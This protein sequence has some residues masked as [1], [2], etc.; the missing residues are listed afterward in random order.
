MDSL[1]IKLFRDK[2]LGHICSYLFTFYTCC[3]KTESNNIYKSQKKSTLIS[4]QVTDKVKPA[5]SSRGKLGD[6]EMTLSEVK[7][8]FLTYKNNFNYSYKGKGTD[9][10][11]CILANGFWQA[12]GYIGGIFRSELNFY[13]LC[14]ATQL[15]SEECVKFFLK[16]DK[17][18]SNKGTF[19]ITLNSFGKFVI[20]YRLSGWDTFFSVFVPYF[21]MLYGAKY[22]AIYKLKEIYK[23]KNFIKKNPDNMN[24]VLFIKLVYSLTPHSPRYKLS[25]EDKLVSLNL[26]PV[27]LKQLPNLSYPENNI[28]S[29]FL[30]ILGFFLGDGTLHLKMEWKRT[31]STIVILPLFN[32]KQSNVES[33]RYIIEE[34]IN[35]L[36]SLGIKANLEK[37]SNSFTLIVKGIDN[38]FNDLFRSL[39]EYSHFLYWKR[40]SF[41]LLVWVKQ[42][43]RSGAHHTYLGLK[44]LIDKVYSSTNQRFTD[45][46]IWMSRLNVWLNA[47][48][49]RLKWGEYYISPIYTSK[50]EIRGWQVR[51]PTTLKIPS[52][53]NKAFISSTCGGSCKAFTSAVEYRDKIISH[54]INNLK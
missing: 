13:P 24:K 50:K 42:L 38:V 5:I 39:T 23:L 31:N 30:F 4:A 36:N 44:L 41:N 11:F 45:K 17:S 3:L 52:K 9:K 14:T 54:W 22:Q 19:S 43:V 26:D 51:F 2:A 10:E 16:L 25:L 27:L 1:I 6:K 15:L 46:E 28:S 32:I 33:N 20:I 48:S 37:N 35:T 53:S 34:M 12:E 18:L 21:N 47:V 29:C 40:D 49:S 8:W 7:D